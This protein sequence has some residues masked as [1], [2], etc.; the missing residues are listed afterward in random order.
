[1]QQGIVPHR[2]MSHRTEISRVAGE[3]IK[4][5][6]GRL[7]R[8]L[9]SLYLLAPSPPM[10]RTPT[11]SCQAERGQGGEV[12]GAGKRTMHPPRRGAG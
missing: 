8:P 5:G 7:G 11:P 1:M 3:V 4:E 9:P 6:K 12:N 2:R 10:A